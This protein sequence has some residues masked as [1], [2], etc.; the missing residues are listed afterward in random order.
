M[1]RTI[2]CISFTNKRLSMNYIDALTPYI[3]PITTTLTTL[4][5]YVPIT[6]NDLKFSDQRK[7]IWLDPLCAMI[8]LSILKTLPE[9]TKL[10]FHDNG[11]SFD[12]PTFLQ[13]YIR[14]RNGNSRYDLHN[15]TSAI[16][17]SIKWLDITNNQKYAIIIKTAKEGLSKM[18][19]STYRDDLMLKQYLTGIHLKMLNDAIENKAIS[20]ADFKIPNH[21]ENPLNQ[22]S[23]KLWFKN[24]MLDEVSQQLLKLDDPL[25]SNAIKSRLLDKMQYVTTSHKGYLESICAGRTM[26]EPP[27][28]TECEI[29]VVS[30]NKKQHNEEEND[31]K[32]S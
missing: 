4:Q 32:D 29:C 9:G 13:S 21:D 25:Q 18:I 17:Y 2:F 10:S 1:I 30:V 20:A 12:E 31:D 14:R 3:P 26:E 7:E 27:E 5:A 15:L 6:P 16:Y 22:R 8:A 24:Q 23:Q 28:E 11:I 19:E